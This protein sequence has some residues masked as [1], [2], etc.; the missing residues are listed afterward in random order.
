MAGKPKV[1]LL[2]KIE[3][4]AV[5]APCPVRLLVVGWTGISLV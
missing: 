5:D 2:G 1:L 3:Q 4:Y